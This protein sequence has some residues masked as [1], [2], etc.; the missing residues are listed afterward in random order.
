MAYIYEK[1]MPKT[2]D[3]T[4]FCLFAYFR[5]AVESTWLLSISSCAMV[6]NTGLE[7][8]R[9]GAL[10]PK[11]SVSTIPPIPHI[12]LGVAEVYWLPNLSA[13]PPYKIKK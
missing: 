5:N 8:A 13:H 2:S 4:W 9:R 3:S 6:G 10:V 1:L 7:P 11:T 12:K